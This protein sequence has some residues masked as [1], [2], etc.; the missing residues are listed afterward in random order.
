MNRIRAII[1]DD[2][3]PARTRIRTLLAN[4]RDIEVVAETAS[5]PDT[6]D[7][8]IKLKPNLLFLDIQM[9]P[10]SGIDV[11]RAVCVEHMPC[12]IFTTAHAEHAL[13]A[14]AVH[15]LDYLLKPFS[16]ARFYEAVERACRQIELQSGRPDERLLALVQASEADSRHVARYLVRTNERYIVLPV[17]EVEW[18]ES[19][20]NYIVAHTARGN[21]VLRKSM[22]A[23]EAELDPRKF[24]RVSRGAAVQFK[25]VREV[26]AITAGEH[27]VILASGA[28]IPMTRN[29]R[30]FQAGLAGMRQA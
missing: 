30:D 8:V 19:A 1:A 10:P 14:F 26:Q 25:S 7:R 21:H 4:L 20:A 3:K 23:L 24:F 17:D 11:L 15:A 2:E 5:G 9:P 28:R 16:P 18:F 22:T 12:T 27:V 6:I 13:E 29:L